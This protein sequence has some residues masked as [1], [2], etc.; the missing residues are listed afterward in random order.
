MI[1]PPTLMPIRTSFKPFIICQKQE[2]LILYSILQEMFVKISITI[3]LPT[4]KGALYK[5]GT[6]TNLILIQWK[7]NR[8]TFSAK[9]IHSAMLKHIMN[10]EKASRYCRLTCANMKIWT[11]NSIKLKIYPHSGS[12]GC[13][14]TYERNIHLNA[15]I[16]N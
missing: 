2:L 6:E 7:Y 15:Y 3:T 5:N 12:I 14:V 1:I 4:L 16:H 9:L 11:I 10:S 13:I 8:C